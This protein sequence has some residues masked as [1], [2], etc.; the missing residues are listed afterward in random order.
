MILKAILGPRTGSDVIKQINFY[1][2]INEPASDLTKRAEGIIISHTTAKE[3]AKLISEYNQLLAEA[4]SLFLKDLTIQNLKPITYTKYDNQIVKKLVD[5]ARDLENELKRLRNQYPALAS[6]VA[7]PTSPP[8][9]VPF[10]PPPATP[11]DPAPPIPPPFQPV[12]PAIPPSY[13]PPGN[14]RELAKTVR[15]MLG[16]SLRGKPGTSTPI[17]TTQVANDIEFVSTH[18]LSQ[19]HISNKAQFEYLFDGRETFFYGEIN[20]INKD[21]DKNTWYIDFGLSCDSDSNRCRYVRCI[22]T[23][24]DENKMNKIRAVSHGR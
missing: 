17:P 12:P 19:V 16:E 4:K 21:H 13:T 6:I 24:L 15:L 23:D 5:A 7:T 1:L 3:S 11:V 20:E 22:F 8:T 18:A 10:Q 2:S 14:Q 9:G